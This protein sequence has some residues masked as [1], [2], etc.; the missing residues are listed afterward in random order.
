MT[1]GDGLRLAAIA[2]GLGIAVALVREAGRPRTD[3][4]GRLGASSGR[5]RKPPAKRSFEPLL[6]AREVL[7]P[8]A[9]RDVELF[10]RAYIHTALDL[11]RDNSD[12]AISRTHRVSDVAEELTAGLRMEAADF[13][14]RNAA[15]LATAGY[16][17]YMA[18]YDFFLTRNGHGA[19]FWDADANAP[20]APDARARLTDA[21]HKAGEDDFYVGDDGRIYGSGDYHRA[22]LYEGT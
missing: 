4:R 13:L 14:A 18:G 22:Q 2:A 8:V 12:Q 6:F 17:A 11:S 10:V 15:D 9:Q 3:R 19:G 7:P 5:P 1:V 20:E 16:G 21:A